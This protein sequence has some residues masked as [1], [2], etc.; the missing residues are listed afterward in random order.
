[1][2]D[3]P[4][5]NDTQRSKLTAL[6]LALGSGAAAVAHGAC[7]DGEH[8]TIRANQVGF[9][10]DGAKLAIVATAAKE[11]VRWTLVDRDGVVRLSGTGDAFGDDTLSGERVQRVD[12]SA[13]RQTGEGFRIR[14]GCA[15]SHPFRIG[16][17]PYGRLPYD[18]LAYFYHN[19][20]GVPIEA[21]YAGGERWARPAGHP[22]DIATCRSG[23]DA[24]GNDWPGC[25]YRLDVTGGWYDAGDQGKYV[26]NAGISVWT[27]L[28]LYEW[29]QAFGYADLFADGRASIPEAGNGISD[30]LDEARF[31]LEFLLRMPGSNSD[32]YAQAFRADHNRRHSDQEPAQHATDA[33][34]SRQRA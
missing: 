21:K 12:F 20:S 2:A 13:A 33:H 16:A 15:E 26:V 11:P 28:D 14:S 27:L 8:A 22:H 18:A 34:Q 6:L 32:A 7:P 3:S 17:E 10:V 9:A 1:M 5:M 29:Q 25:D 30:L 31:E 24:H 23:K 19:R 4:K